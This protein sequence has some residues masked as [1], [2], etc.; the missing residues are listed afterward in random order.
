MVTM[1]AGTLL[2]VVMT[3]SQFAPLVDEDC[4]ERT[5]TEQSSDEQSEG[6]G[7]CISIPTFSLPSSVHLKPSLDAHLLFQILF[8]SETDT[9]YVEL[10]VETPTRFFTTL[11]RVIISPNAP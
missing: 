6:Q 7:T 10:E 9:E 4:A 11:F 1:I 3:F 8:E 2:A 5:N